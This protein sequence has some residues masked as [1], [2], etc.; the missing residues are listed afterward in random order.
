MLYFEYPT[1]EIIF[2][3]QPRGM[4]TEPIKWLYIA[5]YYKYIAAVFIEKAEKLMHVIGFHLK[6]V[7]CHHGG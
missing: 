6:P 4:T 3:G 1:T 5:K 2:T 7:Q